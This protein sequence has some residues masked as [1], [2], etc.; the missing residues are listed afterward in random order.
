MWYCNI[1]VIILRRENLVSLSYTVSVVLEISI[2]RLFEI[3]SVLRP[4]MSFSLL[5]CSDSNEQILYLKD[6]ELNYQQCYLFFFSGQW[7]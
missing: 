4:D 7:W 2:C 5:G 1:R 3:D 6:N